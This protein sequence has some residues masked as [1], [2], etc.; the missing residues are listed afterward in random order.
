MAQTLHTH[1]F[2]NA[3]KPAIEFRN[4]FL[5]FD[6]QTVLND[7]S[8]IHELD[9]LADVKTKVM[10]LEEGRIVFSGPVEKFKTSELPAIQEL[11]TLDH[12]DHSKD[13]FFTDPWDK[14][15]RPNETIL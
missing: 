2:M 5:S 13:P 14:H 7:I 15:R 1:N 10:V 12:H 8:F 11:L 4:V 6:G 9:Y 3:E